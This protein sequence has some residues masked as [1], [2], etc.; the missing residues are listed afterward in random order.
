MKRRRTGERPSVAS[1]AHQEL[2]LEQGEQD[3]GR[4]DSHDGP[5]GLDLVAELQARSPRD[6]RHVRAVPTNAQLKIE[7]ALEFFNASEHVRTVAG[8]ARTLGAPMV[9]A[10]TSLTS[11][12]EVLLTVAW[13]LSWY[14]FAVD[15][16]DPNHPVR[17]LGR[18]E[19]LGELSEEARDWNAHAQPDGSIAVGALA[20]ESANG[21]ESDEVL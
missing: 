4:G 17:V 21:E 3:R 19:E 14:Q 13:E 18:G 9:S 15:L 10:S 2:A 12:A 20:P 8:I 1:A 16:S 7:R 11:A 6:P 5:L